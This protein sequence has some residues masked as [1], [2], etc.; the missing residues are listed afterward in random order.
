MLL[1]PDYRWLHFTR[2][3]FH[4]MPEKNYA[5]A[6]AAL[7]TLQSNAA[8]LAKVRKDSGRDDDKDS[9]PDMLQW[10]RKMDYKP[11]DF[12]VL[13]AIHISGTKGKGSTSA[14]VSSILCQYLQTEPTSPKLHKIGLFTSPHLRFVRERIQIDGEPV[15]ETLFSKYFFEVWNKLSGVGDGTKPSYFRF[16]TVMCLHV[17]LREKV[18]TA[19]IECGIGGEY[20]C[21]NIFEKPSVTA[22]TALGIDHE[23]VL[24]STLQEI[25]WHKA[26]IFR[27]GVPAL[28]VSQR[29]IA[30]EVLKSRA[31]QRDTVLTLVGRQRQVETGEAKLGLAA[32]FQKTNASLAVAIAAAHLTKIGVPNIP[33]LLHDAQASLPLEFERGLELVKW[34]GRCEIRHEASS[35]ISW[36]LDGGHTAES[37]QLAAGWF[38]G[39]V[40]ARKSPKPRFLIFN[41]QTRN[42][43]PLART[44]F[45][46][47]AETLNSRNPFSHVIFTT[48]VTYTETGYTPELSSLNI[49]AKNVHELKVQNELANVWKELDPDASITV[50]QS[51][52][53]AIE[54]VRIMAGQVD[55]PSKDETLVLATGSLH[56]VGGILE[57][58]ESS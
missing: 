4:I 1:R 34:P 54:S 28:T 48:N 42:A 24:G 30:M 3:C 27:P 11:S 32:D 57:V 12:R 29:D 53:E 6:I 56:V 49:P 14:F 47:L 46:T 55:A 36:C 19:I 18:D 39:E 2:R 26:G 50:S 20:D 31:E 43:A 45:A 38:A 37:L 16:L 52:Q 41:Q 51:I 10:I 58:L 35:N 13:N 8:T 17:F 21:T 7:N 15:S 5:A 33:D 22:V 40:L 9:I 23:L 25:A 44:L